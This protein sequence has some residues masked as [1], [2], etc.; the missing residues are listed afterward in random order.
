MRIFR[1]A[2]LLLAFPVL[3][4]IHCA[5]AQ[6]INEAS[7]ASE[8]EVITPAPANRLQT[9]LIR[10]ALVAVN[11]GMLTGNYT[12]VRDLATESFR[13]LYQAG[14]LSAAFDPLRKQ[15][16]DLS[17]VLVTEPLLVRATVDEAAGRLQLEGFFPTRPRP[18]EFVLIFQR[19]D[20]GWMIDELALSVGAAAGPAPIADQQASASPVVS[21]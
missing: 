6:T 1:L 11:H 17:P 3:L 7:A 20:G 13:K 21:Q 10:N 2:S 8:T 18:I 15:K 19:V 9:M 5:A 12:V 16:I 4:Q 14:D